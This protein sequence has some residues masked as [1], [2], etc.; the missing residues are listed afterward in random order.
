MPR[1]KPKRVPLPPKKPR[2]AQGGTPPVPPEHPAAR[3]AII[4][5]V[6]IQGLTSGTAYNVLVRHLMSAPRLGER[7]ENVGGVNATRAEAEE[8][9]RR[10]EEEIRMEMVVGAHRDMAMSYRRV[11]NA[12]SKAYLAQQSATDPGIIARLTSVVGSIEERLSKMR[13]WDE[14]ERLHLVVTNESDRVRKA[15]ESFDE[16]Q[17][18]LLAAEEEEHIQTLDRAREVLALLPG[19][20]T[21][22]GKKPSVH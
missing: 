21:V 11:L 19:G 2:V 3:A 8:A 7:G 6:A 13:G 5:R 14:P 22:E 18:A 4:E 16:E 1:R 10:A 12:A 9:L 15:F 17:I 20:V